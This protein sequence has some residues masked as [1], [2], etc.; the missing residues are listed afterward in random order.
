MSVLSMGT[1][2]S[3]FFEA[4]FIKKRRDLFGLQDREAAHLTYFDRLNANELRL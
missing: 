2:L 4:L 1:T 3:N